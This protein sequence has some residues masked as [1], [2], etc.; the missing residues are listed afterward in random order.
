[1][2]GLG[3]GSAVSSTVGAKACEDA[4]KELGIKGNI[5]KRP[6][7]QGKT[8]VSQLKPDVILLMAKVTLDFGDTPVVDGIPLIT[9]RG[10]DEVKKKI[11]EALLK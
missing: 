9:G 3:V 6:A 1:M 10:K 4:C 11:K 7:M 2:V 8:A 5:Q